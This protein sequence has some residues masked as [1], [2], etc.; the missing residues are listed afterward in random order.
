MA[1][2][3]ELYDRFSEPS[4]IAAMAD[5][6]QRLPENSTRYVSERQRLI[7]RVHAK[8]IP[9][10]GFSSS[11]RGVLQM[12][13]VLSDHGKVE[14]QIKDLRFKIDALLDPQ[15]AA[16]IMAEHKQKE[17]VEDKAQEEAEHKAKEEAKRKSQ[18]ELSTDKARATDVS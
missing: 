10:Y 6:A 7:H 4:F 11:L 14:Q 5:L 1:L 2:Q 16:M 15:S 18:I 17:E 9:K 13:Q 12:V 3:V 8:V